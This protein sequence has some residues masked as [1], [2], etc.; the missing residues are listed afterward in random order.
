MDDCTLWPDRLGSFDWSRCCVLHD[1]AY[2]AG[3]DKL[4]AD[5]DLARCVAS[6]AGWP[7]GLVIFAGVTLGG[8]AFWIKARTHRR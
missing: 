4:G 3:L 7:M 8:W 6:I 2:A 5:L 1:A